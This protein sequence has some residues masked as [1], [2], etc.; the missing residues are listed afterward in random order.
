MARKLNS[1]KKRKTRKSIILSSLVGIVLA[2]MTFFNLSNLLQGDESIFF[3]MNVKQEIATVA[4]SIEELKHKNALTK[5]RINLLKNDPQIIEE[6]ARRRLN[7]VK[8][9]ETLFI[10]PH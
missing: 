4:E 2:V 3:L 7:L 10:F 6:E 5:T 8:E 9:G 1:A